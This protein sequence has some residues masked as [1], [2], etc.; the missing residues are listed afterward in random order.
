MLRSVSPRQDTTGQIADTGQRPPPPNR[1]SP[2]K[3]IPFIRDALFLS[4]KFYSTWRQGRTLTNPFALKGVDLIVPTLQ[5]P[6]SPS[7]QK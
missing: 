7:S 2:R 6:L 5:L 3:K 4:Q 1:L